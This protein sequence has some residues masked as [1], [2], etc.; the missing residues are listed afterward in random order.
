MAPNI[1]AQSGGGER[2]VL[3]NVFMKIA[4]LASM[5]NLSSTAKLNFALTTCSIHAP[6]TAAIVLDTLAPFV[7]GA[8]GLFS[9]LAGIE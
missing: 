5:G 8:F 7:V 1:Q 9:G 3:P 2:G 6:P 4:N